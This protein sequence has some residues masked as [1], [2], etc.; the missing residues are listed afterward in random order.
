VP[1]AA[2]DHNIFIA[3]LISP[4]GASAELINRWRDGDFRLC[5]APELVEE[6]REVLSRPRVREKYGLT[7]REINGL[8][9]LVRARGRRIKV[10]GVRQWCRDVDDDI[11]CEV[12]VKSKASYLVSNDQHL[13]GDAEVTLALRKRGVRVVRVG[14]FLY[15]LDAARVQVQ[16]RGRRTGRRR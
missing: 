1:K 13:C 14:E 3:G 2:V 8:L 15:L 4:R 16:R 6:L 11:L 5:Y 9:Q 10:A 12:A 7:A